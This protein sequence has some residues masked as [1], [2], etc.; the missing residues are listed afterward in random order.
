MKLKFVKKVLS[1]GLV[2]AVAAPT[3]AFADTSCG[4][5]SLC[6]FNPMN[7]KEFRSTCLNEKAL[8]C[9]NKL[10]VSN[11][12]NCIQF[13]TIK[14]PSTQNCG[15]E[16][17][18]CNNDINDE[19]QNCETTDKKDLI[20]QLEDY[21]MTYVGD[22]KTENDSDVDFESVFNKEENNK[23]FNIEEDKNVEA[24]KN[25]DVKLEDKINNETEE[26]K[27]ETS[28]VGSYEQQVLDL[29]NQERSKAGLNAL[30]LSTKLSSVAELKAEDMRDKNYF[31]HTS[32]TYG[33]PFDMMKQFGISY[34]AAGENI[35]KGQRTP[36]SVMNAWM[37]SSGHRANI[38]SS[39]FEQ[40]GIGY[41]T[42]SNGNTYWVQMFIR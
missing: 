32:P 36:E 5:N 8:E 39:N 23:E 19:N 25:E 17:K 3:A 22:D 40:I 21:I 35:A 7:V 18:I 1:V 6:S 29:V 26:L 16:L 13:E 27:E 41:T 14:S 33:S 24:E 31:S 42:D 4:V 11:L 12:G 28:A 37:N 20:N 10:N 38:L 2:I 15:Y 34:S 30:T 9:F